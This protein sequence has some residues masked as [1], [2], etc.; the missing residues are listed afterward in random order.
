M[1]ISKIDN[2][3]KPNASFIPIIN[4]TLK[5]QILCSLILGTGAFVGGQFFSYIH[6]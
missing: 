2:N 3:D 5:E 1:N 6:N 4:A